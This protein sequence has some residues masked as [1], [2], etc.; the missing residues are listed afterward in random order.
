MNVVAAE[1]LVTEMSDKF[2][3]KPPG[4]DTRNAEFVKDL[5]MQ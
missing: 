2:S 1:I 5:S 3:L 4:G